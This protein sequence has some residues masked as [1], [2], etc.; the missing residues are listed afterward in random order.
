MDLLP[1]EI[2]N[3]ILE[4][5]CVTDLKSIRL[6]SKRWASMGE[7][8]LIKPN[9]FS[10][11]NRDDFTRLLSISQHRHLAPCIE[12]LT[13]Y[14]GEMNEYHARQ[15]TRFEQ[16]RKDPG[17]QDQEIREAW[18]EYAQWKLDQQMLSE[19]YCNL[20]LMKNAFER[21]PNLTAINVSLSY[22]PFQHAFLHR[23][24]RIHSTRI[25]S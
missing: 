18:A 17:E 11:P 3:E 19:R 23:I 15:N 20:L 9:F 6:T 4:H 1:V 24:W 21:L 5:L 16:L 2:C 25:L 7:R 13:L 22:C 8:Y 12:T 10:F 14:A